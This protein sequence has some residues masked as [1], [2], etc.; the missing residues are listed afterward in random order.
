MIE[1]ALRSL[2][3]ENTRVAT[4]VQSRVH[5]VHLPQAPVYPAITYQVVTGASEY[6]HDGPADLA[7]LRVQYDLYAA[8][9]LGVLT[10]RDALMHALSGAKGFYGSPPVE[11]Q[12][13]FRTMETD[14]YEQQLERSGPTVWRKTLDFN[15]WFTEVY[16]NG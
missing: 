1:L 12:G 9:H 13:V 4:L 6:S 10:L 2:L 16:D 11:V 8:D 14:A 15:V 3:L 5:P 7:N